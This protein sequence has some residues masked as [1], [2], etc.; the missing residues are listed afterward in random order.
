HY[1]VVIYQCSM[2]NGN[3][4]G[5]NRFQ[6]S[7]KGLS[8]KV[9]KQHLDRDIVFAS[10]YMHECGHTLAIENPAVDNGRSAYPWQYQYWKY[11]PYKSVMNYGYMFLMVDYSDGSRGMNDFNDW[12]TMD[13]KAFKYDFWP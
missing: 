6:I 2:A 12:T 8:D 4:F 1:G 7:Y 9:R 10:A 5:A 3:A 13:L 11:R